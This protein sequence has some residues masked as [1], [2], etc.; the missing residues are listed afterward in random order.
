MQLLTTKFWGMYSFLFLLAIGWGAFAIIGV[1]EEATVW[2]QWRGPDRDGTIQA[3]SWPDSLDEEHLKTVWSVKLG[4]SYSGPIVTPEAVFVT[5][6]KDS[7]YEVVKALKRDSGEELWSTQWEGAM[8]VPFFAKAN[9]DWI[10][11]TPALD[12]DTLYVA[13]M[14]DVLVALDTKTGKEKW[15]VDFM[16]ELKKP[17]HAFGF[18][19]SPL[20]VGDYVYVQA[21]GGFNKLKKQTGEIVWRSLDDGGGMWGSAFSSP[22]METLSGQKQ[23]LVQTRTKLA[24]VSP[25]DGK[26][27]WSEEIPAF[28]GMNILTPTVIGDRVFTSSYGG[29]SFLFQIQP[30][31]EKMKA[32][33]Q[34]TNKAQGYMSSP[35]VIGDYIYLHLKNR[36]FTCIDTKTGKEQWTT[37]PYGQ[38]W[39]MV[40]NGKKI[41]ALDQRGGLLLIRHNP[42]EFELLDKR[43]VSDD[44][45]WAHLAILGDQVF[46]RALKEMIVLKWK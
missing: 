9:G 10:R 41:L 26:V 39:S 30:G 23:L 8:N 1:A 28:R 21:G 45:T 4:P 22:T 25:E 20:V 42:K 5:E 19:C 27:L 3:E 17:L 37:K 38:Y 18:V 43:R 33:Q 40:T 12:G 29:K 35:V 36:R 11:S 32:S 2:P 6:T 31:E 34:W 13:G 14:R 44:S 7:K 15:K 46:V 16:K 24:G